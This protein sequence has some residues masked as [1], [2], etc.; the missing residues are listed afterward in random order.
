[1]TVHL[2]GAGCAGPLWMTLEGKRLLERA[3][4]VVY[5]SLIH[6]D[7]LQLAPPGCEFFAAGK[8]KGMQGMK[9]HEINALLVRLG[10]TGGRIVRLKGGDPFIFGRGGEEA[11]ALESEGIPW[12]YTPGITA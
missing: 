2:V 3:D 7:L 12:T 5:D 10:K 11:Q 1:M 8:R 4:A 6:P 9:Q